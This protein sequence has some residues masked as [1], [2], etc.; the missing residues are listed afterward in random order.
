M[1]DN[2]QAIEQVIDRKVSP[3]V[4]AIKEIRQGQKEL[5]RAI[6]GYN[7]SSGIITEIALLK[8]QQEEQA[9]RQDEREN[10]AVSWGW[11]RDKLVA[12]LALGFLM[13]LLFTVL[14]KLMPL[15]GN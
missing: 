7:G 15:L 5:E 8:Q 6:R 11:I 4:E 1:V 14:P 10:K 12:P 2:I 9:I 3:L 13:W